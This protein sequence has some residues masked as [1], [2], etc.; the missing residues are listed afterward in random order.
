[1]WISNTATSAMMLPIAQAV[2]LEIKEQQ[3]TKRENRL[4]EHDDRHVGMGRGA[5]GGARDGEDDKSV[6]VR[7]IR[8]Y[9]DDGSSR[10]ELQDDKDV[11]L[12][13]DDKCDTEQASLVSEQMRREPNKENV[14]ALTLPERTAQ[15][16]SVALP[17]TNHSARIGGFHR[18]TKALMLGVAYSANIGGTATLTGTGPNLVLSGD[19]N[20]WV[21]Q[22][23]HLS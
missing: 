8:R 11:L 20:R 3:F 13:D 9:S 6:S 17:V 15:S 14:E 22:Q 7:Y 19:I 2:L 18:L 4:T 21:E 12:R 1:M 10:A 5:G 23:W 16:N